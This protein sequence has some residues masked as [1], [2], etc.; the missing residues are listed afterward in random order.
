MANVFLVPGKPRIMEYKNIGSEKVS[1][2]F[3]FIFEHT[4]PTAVINEVKSHSVGT[5]LASLKNY[6]FYFNKLIIKKSIYLFLCKSI[7]N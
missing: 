7:C 4:E 6:L 5:L 3:T 1:C 2:T